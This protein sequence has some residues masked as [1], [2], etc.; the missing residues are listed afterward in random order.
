MVAVVMQIESCGHPTVESNA[1]ANGLFQV[2]P[3]HFEAGENPIHPE[4]NAL[5]GLNYLHDSLR[6]SEGNPAL[7]LA[8]YNGGHGVIFLPSDQWADETQRYVY[9]G[10]GILKDINSG[11]LY[12]PTLNDWLHAGGQSLCKQASQVLLT[13]G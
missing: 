7:A 13:N 11:N 6:L 9:W 4:T 12:S 2:M 10:T 8:G 3:F 5:R 1:G